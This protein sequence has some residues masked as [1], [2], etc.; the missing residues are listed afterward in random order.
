MAVKKE[1][2]QEE[3]DKGG[4]TWPTDNPRDEYPKTK[5]ETDDLSKL[6]ERPVRTGRT[7]VVE[8]PLPTRKPKA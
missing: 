2:K 5:R 1:K 4:S 3:E 6:H 8:K 7:T